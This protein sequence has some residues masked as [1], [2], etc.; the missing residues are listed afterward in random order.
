[1]PILE[2]LTD[3]HDC[4]HEWQ[5]VSMVFETQ[6]LD[7]DG[8]VMVRQPDLDRGRLYLVCLLCAQHTYM[9]TNWVGYFLGG[10]TTRGFKYNPNSSHAYSLD[11]GQTWRPEKPTADELA[12]DEDEELDE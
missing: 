3:P 6:L 2:N 8:R 1:M 9:T 10:S 4:E 5:P 12:D 7:P 11:G